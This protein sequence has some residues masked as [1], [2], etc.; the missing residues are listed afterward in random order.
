MNLLGALLSAVQGESSLFSLRWFCL[1]HD[2]RVSPYPQGCSSIHAIRQ[3][4]LH[5]SGGTMFALVLGM[6]ED[7]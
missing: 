3:G 2:V 7:I 6:D 4:K 5:N 1:R